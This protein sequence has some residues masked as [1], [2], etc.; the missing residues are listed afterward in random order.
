MGNFDERQ[1]GISVSAVSIR[2]GREGEAQH[3]VPYDRSRARPSGGNGAG[4]L[5]CFA[6]RAEAG[7]ALFTIWLVADPGEAVDTPR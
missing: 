4:W 6:E 7:R 1:W 2:V 5:R 3:R